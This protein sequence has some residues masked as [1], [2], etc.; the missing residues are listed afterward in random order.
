MPSPLKSPLATTFHPGAAGVNGTLA[1]PP[2][3]DISHSLVVPAAFC[4]RMS[5]VPSPLKSPL[6]ATAVPGTN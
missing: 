4:H 5:V 6:A 1:M 2:L 3:G